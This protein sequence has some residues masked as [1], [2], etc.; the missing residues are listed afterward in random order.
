MTKRETTLSITRIWGPDSNGI[1][2]Y[3]ID[4]YWRPEGRRGAGIIYV[5]NQSTFARAGTEEFPR[6]A[7]GDLVKLIFTWNGEYYRVG[8]N[9][10]R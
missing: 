6:L 4:T 5:L 7:V 9:R 10:K 8:K 1:V 3:R 2:E